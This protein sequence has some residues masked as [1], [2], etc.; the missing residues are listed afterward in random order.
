MKPAAKLLV[1][2]AFIFSGQFITGRTA[3]LA[4]TL[5]VAHQNHTPGSIVRFEH[6]TTRDGLSQNSGQVIFQDS[7]GFLW[8][9]T[10]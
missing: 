2:L 6:L 4:E 1:V 3:G 5:P 8:I 7:R 9:G 10:Q